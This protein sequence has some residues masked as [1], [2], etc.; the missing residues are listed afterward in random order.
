MSKWHLPGRVR[1]VV[2]GSALIRHWA[3]DLAGGASSS[4]PAVGASGKPLSPAGICHPSTCRPTPWDPPLQLW[5]ERCWAAREQAGSAL[6]PQPCAPRIRSASGAERDCLLCSPRREVVPIWAL[7]GPVSVLTPWGT[8]H[9]MWLFFQDTDNYSYWFILLLSTGGGGNTDVCQF[10]T[11]LQRHFVASLGCFHISSCPIYFDVEDF[12]ESEILP[13]RFSRSDAFCNSSYECLCFFLS[14]HLHGNAP[15]VKP[16]K[17]L[18]SSFFE[19]MNTFPCGR[20]RIVMQ[21][22]SHNKPPFGMW[23]HLDYITEDFRGS[24]W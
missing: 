10:C 19:C 9:M 18:Q 7:R 20:A 8:C 21:G 22:L 23:R 11:K 4:P 12:P 6:S 24:L 3:G 16:H 13:F 17:G 1:S 14:K 15:Y 2:E 5:V